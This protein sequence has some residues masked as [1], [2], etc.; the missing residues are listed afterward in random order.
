MGPKDGLGWMRNVL[1]HTTLTSAN[2]SSVTD[3]H[4]QSCPMSQLSAG[5]CLR[6][7]NAQ[8]S[9]DDLFNSGHTVQF[10][11]IKQVTPAAAGTAAAVDR[12]RIILSDG[13][14]FLQAMLATQ[15]NHLVQDGSINKN[16]I[17]IIDKLTCN[18]VQGKRYVASRLHALC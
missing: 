17:A 13:E 12:Y 5:I 9:D 6:L 8:S 18:F 10:L 1:R 4:P 14:H 7:H 16:T 2:A 3:S 11:S 15:L